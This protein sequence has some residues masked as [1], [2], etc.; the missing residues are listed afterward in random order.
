MEGRGTHGVLAVALRTSAAIALSVITGERWHAIGF[1]FQRENPR[2]RST[3]GEQV[4][5][6]DTQPAQEEDE[7]YEVILF[8][9]RASPNGL[10]RELAKGG[11]GLNIRGLVTLLPIQTLVF[12]P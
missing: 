4:G 9:T 12:Y 1:Y 3:S 10:E 8:R 5:S 2:E 11:W 7:N 6:G